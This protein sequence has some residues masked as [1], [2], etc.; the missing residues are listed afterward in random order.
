[1]VEG[2]QSLGGSSGGV[3]SA[4]A[5]GGVGSARSSAVPGGVSSDEGRV[6]EG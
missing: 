6:D 3:G 4:G 2:V 1:M 5:P